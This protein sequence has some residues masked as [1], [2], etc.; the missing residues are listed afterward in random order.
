[1]PELSELDNF[2]LIPTIDAASEVGYG[3]SEPRLRSEDVPGLE[4]TQDGLVLPE[5]SQPIHDLADRGDVGQ[6]FAASMDALLEQ[7]VDDLENAE[8]PEVYAQ[9]LLTNR[10]TFGGASLGARL[11]YHLE[12]RPPASYLREARAHFEFKKTMRDLEERSG[13]A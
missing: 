4:S 3:A 13:P 7:G 8:S 10:V 9:I 2:D 1:V 11:R 6:R 5:R 12:M